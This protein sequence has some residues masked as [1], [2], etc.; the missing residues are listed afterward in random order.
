M[1]KKVLT[2]TPEE[3][4]EE[5]EEQAMEKEAAMLAER[6][7]IMEVEAVMRTEDGIAIRIGRDPTGAITASR[8]VADMIETTMVGN[9][10][11]G[12][13]GD[14]ITTTEVVKRAEHESWIVLLTNKRVNRRSH[15]HH[16]LNKRTSQGAHV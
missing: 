6:E 13:I 1:M 14:A 11:N 12:W 9:I 4:E 5:E 8:T 2:D 10:M 7:R 3:M 15:L 16:R